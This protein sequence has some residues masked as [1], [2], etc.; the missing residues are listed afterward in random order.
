LVVAQ[1][2]GEHPTELF[3]KPGQLVGVLVQP[4][5]DG[6]RGRGVDRVDLGE[7]PLGQQPPTGSAEHGEL[8]CGQ[9]LPSV[10]GPIGRARYVRQGREHRG[11]RV[12][13][14][15]RDRLGEGER[16]QQR[17]RVDLATPDQSDPPLGSC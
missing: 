13:R 15:G 12:G 6:R 10:V 11:Q 17:G 2:R 3:G 4:Q 9:R 5:V 16:G 8:D 1:P 14:H 7:P